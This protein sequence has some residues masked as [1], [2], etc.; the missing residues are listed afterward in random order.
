MKINQLFSFVLLLLV[1]CG[2]QSSFIYTNSSLKKKSNSSLFREDFKWGITGHPVTKE[3]YLK[4]SI[5]QQIELIKEHQFDFYGFEV[6]PNLNG[7]VT[8]NNERFLQLLRAAQLNKIEILTCISITPHLED[9]KISK[10][11][12][13]E[14]GKKQAHGY[15]SKY[16]NYLDYYLL[17]NEQEIRTLVNNANGNKSEDYDKDKIQIL[18]AYLKGMSEG[19]KLADPTAKRIINMAGWLHW[20]YFRKLEA[21]GVEY[22]IL[23]SHWYSDMGSMLKTR[24]YHINVLD[25]IR[26]FG[27]PIWITENNKKYG[28]INNS[29]IEQKEVVDYYMKEFSNQKSID[30][31]FIYELLDEPSLASKSLEGKEEANYGI[32]KYEGEIQYKPVSD[33]IKY[34]IEQAKHGN[35]N[36]VS[37][38]FTHLTG[39]VLNKDELDK[40]TNEL[41]R[42]NNYDAILNHLLQ[43][44]GTQLFQDKILAANKKENEIRPLIELAYLKYLNRSPTIQEAEFWVK[45]LSKKKPRKHID[46]TLLLSN[47]FWQNAIWEGYE[48][49][50]GYKRPN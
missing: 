8:K 5:D 38:L 22:D 49:R 17:G 43:V 34:N 4:I 15:A 13:Y 45:K 42:Y 1:L 18:A 40:W 19:I 39:E 25:S 21:A 37:Q 26:Q 30:V 16:G 29:E 32:L 48:K 31:Y 33:I 10:T 3:D 28:S 50:T 14:R 6:V 24:T 20:E 11:I 12:A 9:F 44:R 36:Y 35:E 2:C 46:K 7:E 27:K 41:N 47:E 23:G